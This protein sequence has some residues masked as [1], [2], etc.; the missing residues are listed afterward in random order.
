MV[1]IRVESLNIFSLS[2]PWKVY[3]DQD[4]TKSK[5]AIFLL[6]DRG[7]SGCG[8]YEPINSVSSTTRHV[9]C[10]GSFLL[11]GVKKFA[12]ALSTSREYRHLLN[13]LA[14]PQYLLVVADA[15]FR[16]EGG[17]DTESLALFRPAGMLFQASLVCPRSIKLTRRL[18][19]NQ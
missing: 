5:A 8:L 9:N 2:S 4:C 6:F 13:K 16:R 12:T 11:V 15:T 7:S 14:K 19:E 17:G 1:L 10:S 18:S 3:I